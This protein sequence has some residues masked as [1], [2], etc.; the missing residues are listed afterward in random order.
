MQ[1]TEEQALA[2]ILRHLAKLGWTHYELDDGDSEWQH[3]EDNSIEQVVE[4]CRAVEACTLRFLKDGSKTGV[5]L[6]VWGN[7][8][9]EL[10]ADHSESRG[11][12]SDVDA[13]LRSIWPGYPDDSASVPE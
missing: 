1:I 7:V 8:A 3:I 5:M 6:L 10:V 11:F 4:D 2:R 13:A 12:G 9:S